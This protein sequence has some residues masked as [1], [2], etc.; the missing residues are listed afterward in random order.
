MRLTALVAGLFLATSLHAAQDIAPT[1][2]EELKLLAELPVDD[3]P[4]GNLS[5]LA[6][7]GSELLGISDRDDDRLYRLQEKDG[8][9]QATAE[10]FEAPSAP[11]SGLPWGVRMRTWASGLF[12]GGNLDFEGLACDGAGNRYLVSEANA[13]VLRVSASGSAEWLNLPPSLVRQA[14]AS[15]MLLNF[16]ALFE[17]IAI[18]AKGERLWLA[19]ERER[20]GLLLLHNKE[21]GWRCNDGCVLLSQAGQELS[22]VDPASGV[23]LSRDFADLALFDG[24]LFTLERSAHR[25][26]RRNADDGKL[27][28]CWSFLA[29][30]MID[31]RRYPGP[32][33]TAEALS[34]DADGAWV[35]L[36]NND[37]ARA[38]GET[39]PIVWHFAAPK[40]G[41]SAP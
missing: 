5:G 3:L 14:R 16:N 8:A 32:Y 1:E 18:D 4:A 25:I 11:A 31:G 41:W 37:Q 9:L 19:A 26:C 40:G 30:A 13:S 15:G 6:R 23:K 21:G 38:D 34:M 2:P 27:E 17:G 39:R 29:E 20:R 7:C 33:G 35:G 36:D 22:R 10:L 24:K 12:R 28:K